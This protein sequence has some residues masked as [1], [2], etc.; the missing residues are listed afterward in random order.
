MKVRSLNAEL[1]M[2]FG[3]TIG[4]AT[5][6][7]T[8]VSGLIT[9]VAI[10]QDASE[11]PGLAKET[12]LAQN[13][14]P[15]P[16]AKLLAAP[17]TNATKL[18]LTPSSESKVAADGRSRI[19]FSGRILDGAGALIEED[20][21]VTLTAS[22]GKFIGVDADTDAAGF[23]VRAING[24]FTVELQADLKP[25]KVRVRAG[26]EPVLVKT[27]GAA[28]P[29]TQFANPSS[30]PVEVYSE[31]EFIPNLRSGL[32]SG[33]LKL[34]IGAAGTDYYDSFRNYLKPGSDGTAITGGGAIFATGSLGDWAFTGA[35][36]S[37]RSL[38]TTCNGTNSLFKA[39]QFC[40]QP[41]P[42]YGD[43]SKVDFLAPSIDSVYFKL[44]RQ[45]PIPNAGTDYAMWGDYKTEEFARPSQLYSGTSRSLHGF[46]GNYNVGDLQVSLMYGNNLQGFQRDAIAPNGTSGY[47]FVSRRLV[48]TGSENVFVETEE[49]NRPGTVIDRTSLSRGRDYE[50]DYDRG[51]VMFRRPVLATEY[52]PFGRTLVRR[53]IVTYQYDGGDGGGANLYAGRAQY[54]LARTTG[55]ESWFAGTY[56]K[57]N[58]GSQDFELYGGDAQISLGA[59]SKF[60]AEYARSSNQTPFGQATGSAYRFELNTQLSSQ[61]AAKAYYRSVEEGFANNATF[62]FAPGQ[63]RW[64]ASIAAQ[65]TPTTQLQALYEKE[66]NYGIAPA[67]RS[68]IESLYNP[69]VQAA[70]GSILNNDLTTFSAGVTQKFGSSALSVDWVSRSRTDRAGASL[71]QADSN[72]LVSRLTVPIADNLT[73][74]AQNESSLGANSDPVYRDRSIVGL[75]WKAFPGVT[76]R[77]AQQFLGSSPFLNSSST[78]A[79]TSFTTV[80]TLLDQKLSDDTSV[81]GRYSILNGING[82][83]SQGALGLQHRFKL[84]PGLRVNVGYERVFGDL[85]TYT[86]SGQQFLQPYAVGQSASSLGL[87]A[88]D[89][90]SLGFEYTDNPDFKTSA[91]VEHRSGSSGSNTLF[92]AAATGKLSPALTVLA[93]YQQ[94]NYA[95]QTL[96]GF[97]DTKN[98][99]LGLAYRDPAQDKFNA[100]LRYEYR[101][102][103]DSN[104]NT[105]LFGT[106]S[107][108]SA[109]LFA[110][111]GIY[112]PNYRW[113]FYGKLAMRSTTSYLAKDLVGTNTLTLGQLRAAYKLG[114]QW[115]IAM[116]GRWIGQSNSSFNEFGYLL[117]L[118]Y[119]MTPNLRLAAGYS[120]GGATDIDFNGTR[121]RG[122]PY[123]S[124]TA[125]LDDLFGF[126]KQPIAPKQQQESVV[127][128][129]SAEGAK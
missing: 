59:N 20:A 17:A 128:Q 73:F 120:F 74:R 116:E 15:N 108:S 115:D 7:A 39:D 50:F 1:R 68:T 76:V 10:A 34:R 33:T 79:S 93:R 29:P 111:E 102:N 112:T 99:K 113:E 64:G 67:V 91:R 129:T 89:S 124:I 101:E 27:Q 60:T 83:S 88:G 37:E 43:S 82:S 24:Q 42:V 71:L 122:G 90:Y 55:Q 98:L 3:L 119:Y 106:G 49:L 94:A 41:Y 16:P 6:L 38:N 11:E 84:S 13:T 69:G 45:S 81:T 44:E 80:E 61:V 72:Q 100:L 40:D 22:G 53:I 66:A 35:Y 62:S 95:N 12:L 63:T 97:S 118:G 51:S 47:Y 28:I 36:N 96:I 121:S 25:Q 75:D 127:S 87:G 104:P 57:E 58:L 125:K 4:L 107:G 110:V 26:L 103:P 21:I 117:E 31:V 78:N 48:Q 56:L 14:T 30:T 70:P 54:N 92:N 52:D 46:K 123:L 86:G 114:Y 9:D 8:I 5:V 105:L 65:V 77:V 18:E 19:T 32:V 23:Q 85:Y 126:G 109:H 2:N